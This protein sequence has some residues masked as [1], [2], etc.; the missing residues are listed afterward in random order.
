MAIYG[1]EGMVH[2][3]HWNR[4]W[5]FKVHDGKGELLSHDDVNEPDDHQ[6]NFIDSIKSGKLPAADIGIGHL[7][8]LHC[9]LANIVARSGVNFEFDAETETIPERAGG[10]RSHQTPLPHSL[11]HAERCV[12]SR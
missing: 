11:G 9:H 10:Q 8:G 4:R 5:G 12:V 7:S 1:S 3:G 2:I 6:Q